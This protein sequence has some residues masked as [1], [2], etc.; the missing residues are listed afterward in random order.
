MK[1]SFK[2]HEAQEQK[3]KEEPWA[4]AKQPCA[5][6]HKLLAGAYGQWSLADESTVWTCSRKCDEAYKEEQK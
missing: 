2:L 5:I 3:K 1:H 4:V 6:C